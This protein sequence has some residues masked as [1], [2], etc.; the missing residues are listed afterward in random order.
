MSVTTL[1]C[2]GCGAKLQVTGISPAGKPVRCPS[3]RLI[4]R[5]PLDDSEQEY[6]VNCV[7]CGTTLRSSQPMRPGQLAQCPECTTIFRVPA[8]VQQEKGKPSKSKNAARPA[9]SDYFE[10]WTP[11]PGRQSSQ[12]A[13]SPTTYSE[14]VPLQLSVYSVKEERPIEADLVRPW[15]RLPDAERIERQIEE[16][17]RRARRNLIV[18]VVIIVGC[19][20]AIAISLFFIFRPS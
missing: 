10:P 15:D 17:R 19:L 5:G 6:E 7:D 11:R 12:A 3:C 9:V 20:A 8:F 14:V 2:P 16:R 4:F 18:R 1:D 13:D